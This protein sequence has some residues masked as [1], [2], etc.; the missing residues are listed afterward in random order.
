MVEVKNPINAGQA[1]NL[2]HLEKLVLAGGDPSCKNIPKMDAD[3]VFDRGRIAD[4]VI[5]WESG[6]N[7]LK[8]IGDP[9]AGKTSLVT[10][11][12]A[13][14]NWPLYA[15]SCNERT[16]SDHLIGSFVPQADGKFKFNYGVV[17]RAALEG[18]SVL[19]DEGNAL[20]PNAVLSL[21][22]LMEGYPIYIPETGETIYAKPGFRVFQTENEL[23]SK[24]PIAGRYSHDASSEDRY[25][26][27]KVD[28]L[29]AKLEKVIVMNTLKKAGMDGDMLEGTATSLMA[30]AGYTRRAYHDRQ[31][32]VIKPMSTRVLRRWAALSWAY[33]GVTNTGANPMLHALE[34]ACSGVPPAMMVELKDKFTEL[35]GV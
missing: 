29:E 25:M 31:S 30:L 27:I 15:V 33:R 3:Y 11:W 26:E 35:V 23:S 13:R 8:I 6:F 12:H 17:V 28:Y 18:V 22:M 20:E 24:L 7:A 5:F 19:L 16:T 21:H 34:R 9:A 14:M 32:K 10:E 4:M 1:F 2:P